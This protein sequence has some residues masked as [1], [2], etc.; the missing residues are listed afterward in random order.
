MTIEYKIND[1]QLKFCPFG[2]SDLECCINIANAI[3]KGNDWI[4]EQIENLS[5]EYE[6]KLEKIDPVATCLDAILQIAR[7]E[8]CELIKIDLVD[9]K[10]FYANVY[11]N[12]LDSSFCN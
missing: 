3:N 10:N 1:L 4:F 7:N 11:A 6:T 12:Y 9:D 5:N 8:L 2:Y